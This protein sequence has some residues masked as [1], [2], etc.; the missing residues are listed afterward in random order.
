MVFQ[1]A[2][3]TAYMLISVSIST[4]YDVLEKIKR[5]KG[6]EEA[7]IVY[8]S[9]DILVKIEVDQMKDLS[10]VVTDIRRIEGIELS[11]TL[12]CQV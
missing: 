8:G 1:V 7:Y 2:S 12:V 9:W 5:I 11:E 6:V 10:K 4:E 3:V